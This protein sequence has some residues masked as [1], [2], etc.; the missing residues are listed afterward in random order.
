M[1]LS[2]PDSSFLDSF[3][4]LTTISTDEYG[5]NKL[6]LYILKMNANSF[7]YDLLV[8]NLLEPVISYSVSRKVQEEYAN[9][10]HTLTQKAVSH[11]INYC[12]NTGEL[13]EL[14]LYAFLECH[15]NAPKILTKLELKTSTSL[16]INGSDGVHYLKLPNGNYQ[17]IFGESKTIQDPAVAIRDAFSS[18]AN[19]KGEINEDGQKKSGIN[20][21]K[22]LISDNLIKETFSPEDT[23][24][25]S[26]LI[27]PKKDDYFRVDDAFGIF[28]GYEISITASDK[29]LPNDECRE[30]IKKA[31]LDEITGKIALIDKHIVNNDLSGHCFHIYILPFTDL[32][33]NRKDILRK[34]MT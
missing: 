13:G 14:L 28:I 3:E 34:L 7:D 33:Q 26:N 2:V 23:E 16:Y 25:I 5:K 22:S 30:K 19:F 8:R 17:L 20:Y 31:V 27:Y 4:H 24:F 6:N 32:N 9:K 11:F 18:I 1:R 10:P 15:L 29:K 12:K 21:E